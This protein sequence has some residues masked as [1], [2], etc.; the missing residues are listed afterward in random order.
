MLRCTK[1][2]LNYDVKAFDDTIGKVDDFLFMDTDFHIQYLVVNIGPI[3]FGRKV[4]IAPHALGEPDWVSQQVPVNLTKEE[5]KSSPNI[6]T[7]QPI[8]EM[9]LDRLHDY[10]QWPKFWTSLSNTMV[11]TPMTV[12]RHDPN[13]GEPGYQ[14]NTVQLSIQKQ[15]QATTSKL[16]SI[17]E[18]MG[19]K[20][21]G[22]DGTAGTVDDIVVDDKLWILRYLVIKT[23][24]IFNHKNV[25]LA[26]D[27]IDWI[28][29]RESELEVDLPVELIE[30][31]PEFD[32][33]M[34][35]TRR[36]EEVFYDFH[37]K[38]YYWV[39]R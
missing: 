26:A 38:P 37:G 28:R 12:G 3:L 22:T 24:T 17:N 31:S 4:L 25:L 32:P 33:E 35:M 5:I 7:D 15:R 8:S 9:D 10:Y 13:R 14:T 2:I 6:K 29:H 23:G 36:Q 39:K 11:S 30:K 21:S 27:W 16:R 19:Y 20:V 18:V 1:E 34:P